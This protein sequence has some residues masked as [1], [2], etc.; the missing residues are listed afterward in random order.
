MIVKK[1][2]N[3]YVWLCTEGGHSYVRT[4]VEYENEDNKISWHL[5]EDYLPNQKYLSDEELE[6]LF[7]KNKQ[8]NE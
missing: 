4:E 2:N 6:E 5:N 3:R 7:N 1:L 8:V